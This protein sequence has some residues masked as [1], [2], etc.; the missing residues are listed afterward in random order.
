MDQ[1]GQHKPNS[2]ADSRAATWIAEALVVVL[3]LIG[4]VALITAVVLPI[5]QLTQPGGAISVELGPVA[6]Q[7][8]LTSVPNVP[9]GSAL[10][11]V[12]TDGTIQA[13]LNVFELPW[14]LKLLSEAG[15]SVWALCMAGIA[16]LLSLLLRDIYRGR[17]F[18]AKN[19]KRL[20][21]I[22]LLILAGSFA[23]DT[24][25]GIAAVLVSGHVDLE[26][27]LITS[28]HYTWAPLILAGLVF[29]LGD[30]FRRG[31]VLSD[32]ARGLV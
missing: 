13:T 18:S 27:P 8:V 15:T 7:H 20:Q 12:T 6:S 21:L 16:W 14:L 5:N 17:P 11:T 3:I 23:S 19:P 4:V 26:A 10:E 25:N 24:L 31:R 1:A 29:V 28:F 32:D 2:D 9:A 22:A 30:A